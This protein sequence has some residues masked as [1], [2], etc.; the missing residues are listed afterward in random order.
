LLVVEGYPPTSCPGIACLMYVKVDKNEAIPDRRRPKWLARALASVMVGLAVAI[1]VITMRTPPSG[2][3]KVDGQVLLAEH[4]KGSPQAAPA[5]KKNVCTINWFEKPSKPANATQHNGV[6]LPDV[7]IHEE[8]PHHAFIIGDWG[9]IAQ[10]GGWVTPAPHISVRGDYKFVQQ[11]DDRAQMLVRD[12]MRKRA[13]ASKPAYFL[14][15]GDNFYWSG[16]E[17]HCGVPDITR[18]YSGGG[19]EVHNNNK[20]DQ[21]KVIFE[22]MYTGDGIDGKQ[23]LG[24]LGNHDY[25]GWRFDHAWDQ[26]IGYTWSSPTARW[27]TPA[28]Y[29]SVT[30][31]YSDFSVDYYFMDTNVWDALDPHSDTVHNICSSFHAPPETEACHT[32]GLHKVWECPGWFKRLWEDQKRWLDRIVPKSTADWRIVVTHYPPY[33]GSGEWKILAKKHEIDLMITGH[34]H[35]QQLHSKYDPHERIW[36]ND[37]NDK[38]KLTTDFIDPTAWVVSG[39]GGGVTSEDPPKHGG[40]DDQYGFMDLTLSKEKLRVEGISH[41]GVLRKTINIYPSYPHN[42]GKADTVV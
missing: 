36:P 10:N 30:V 7:C 21:F 20:V 13:P 15:V 23:W 22:D 2:S 1:L 35:L 11:V 16:V 27:V 40:A 5:S 26:A 8:G 6:A 42:K 18:I 25:G 12:Q 38:G 17:D 37:P 19:T 9:G 29:W 3:A 4:K 32:A 31:R 39:G 24:I 33:W 28:Q 41:G 34:R 14:N